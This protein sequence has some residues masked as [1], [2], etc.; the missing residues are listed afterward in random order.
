MDN[1]VRLDNDQMLGLASL[2]E[3]SAVEGGSARLMTGTDANGTFLKV[4][5]GRGAG[6]SPAIYG[7]VL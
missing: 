1:I 6:W 7:V 3:N 2:L 4:D 5:A